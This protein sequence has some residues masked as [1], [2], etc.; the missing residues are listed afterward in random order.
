MLSP[1]FRKV[2]NSSEWPCGGNLIKE[3][4]LL[5]QASELEPLIFQVKTPDQTGLC[6]IIFIPGKDYSSYIDLI[7]EKYKET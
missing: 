5:T 2:V 1:I 4:H 3:S 6:S 7:P